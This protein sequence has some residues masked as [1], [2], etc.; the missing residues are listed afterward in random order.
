M[1]KRALSVLAVAVAVGLV[2]TLLFAPAAAAAPRV[3]EARLTGEKEV[4]TQ[5]DANGSGAAIITTNWKKKK[6]CFSLLWRALGPVVFAHIH[7]G[8][9]KVA[10]DVVVGLYVGSPL[11]NNVGSIGGCVNNVG[12]KLIGRIN[13]NP[14]RYYVNI[15]TQRYPDGAIRGQLRVN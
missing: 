7:A 14:Q 2:S 3:F 12:R 6:V 4:D 10:G 8:T 15:H 13:R 11:P 5:G 1:R 9:R